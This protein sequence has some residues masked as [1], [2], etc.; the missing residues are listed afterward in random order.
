MGMVVT[1]TIETWQVNKGALARKL[2]HE[3]KASKFHL[4][5]RLTWSFNQIQERKG[6]STS[7]LDCI[8]VVRNDFSISLQCSIIKANWDYFPQ[9]F[10]SSSFINNKGAAN[11]SYS[12]RIWFQISLAS[13]I[14]VGDI[15]LP[16]F[17]LRTT[18]KFIAAYW[19]GSEFGFTSSGCWTNVCSMCSHLSSKLVTFEV[20]IYR[21]NGKMGRL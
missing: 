16:L 15:V 3:L 13:N 19:V 14:T 4:S 18:F 12:G 20:T 9:F 21:W 5:T 6:G 17:S 8:F 2:W 7:C 10:H 11:S 1:V